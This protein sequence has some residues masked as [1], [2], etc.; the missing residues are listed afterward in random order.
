MKQEDELAL[1]EQEVD[2]FNS[3]MER[4]QLLT[5]QMGIDE[6]TDDTDTPASKSSE[7][8]LWDKLDNARDDFSQF[9]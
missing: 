8:D 5:E 9:E 2:Y 7:D 6:E 4:H 3:M 1:T